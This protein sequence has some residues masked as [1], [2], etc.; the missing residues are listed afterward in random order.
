MHCISILGNFLIL[1][2]FK[3]KWWQY[4]H[5][6]SRNDTKSDVIVGIFF[7]RRILATGFLPT[8]FFHRRIPRNLIKIRSLFRSAEILIVAIWISERNKDLILTRL[9]PTGFPSV[10]LMKEYP[11]GSDNGMSLPREH[12]SFEVYLANTACIPYT[13]PNDYKWVW[14]QLK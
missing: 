9:D 5:K 13:L 7:H 8:S 4:I 14:V 2:S 10:T 6:I 11:V 12:H 3:Q 1:Q